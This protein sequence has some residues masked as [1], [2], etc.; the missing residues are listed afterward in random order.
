MTPVKASKAL[1]QSSA[2]GLWKLFGLR[3]PDDLHLEDLAMARGVFVHDGSLTSA[4]GRLIRSGNQGII[5]VRHG[6]RPATRRRF[7]IAHELGHWEL[8]S[9]VSQVFI[10]TDEDMIA[11]Y[12]KNPIEA[13]ANYFASALLMP[14]KLFRAAMPTGAPTFAVLNQLS[15][16][17]RTSLTATAIRWMDLATDYCA[18][19]VCENGR[20]K[21][22]RGSENFESSMWITAGQRVSSHAVASRVNAQQPHHQA[23]TVSIDTWAEVRDD[24]TTDELTEE[25]I[26]QETYRRTLS[27]LWLP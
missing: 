8:H 17:F 24:L 7:V 20:I 5:R 16:V 18:L 19:V 3:K 21:W 13:E 1:A 14:T 26:Y 11:D 12:R 22:W 4:E 23:D 10:C 9:K 27:L 2:D 15:E 25:S 6:L